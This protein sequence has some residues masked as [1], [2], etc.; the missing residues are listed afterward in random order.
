[1]TRTVQS[2][3]LVGRQLVIL[4]IGT[5][6]PF[7]RH[8]TAP[9]SSIEP[10]LT[11]SSIACSTSLLSIVVPSI[12]GQSLIIAPRV[13][14]A[15]VDLIPRSSVSRMHR[16]PVTHILQVT[17]FIATTAFRYRIPATQ[18]ISFTLLSLS[19]ADS[20]LVA[21]LPVSTHDFWFDTLL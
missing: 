12:V 4:Y 13:S 11:T 5:C 2:C 10:R 18:V 14:S 1:M 9:Y 20:Q 16:S 3:L 15:R 8:I 17:P 19:T 21:K 6:I 7:K